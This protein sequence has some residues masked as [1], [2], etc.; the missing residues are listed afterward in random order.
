[1]DAKLQSV[2]AVPIF[3]PIRRWPLLLLLA[4]FSATQ[5]DA[6]LDPAR[7]NVLLL[8]PDEMSLS[9]LGAVVQGYE[10]ELSRA[11]SGHVV[12]S[13]D[14]VNSRVCSE[15]AETERALAW[16]KTKYGTR[17]FD[18]M[19][20]V[21][22]P[23]TQFAA[24]L[25]TSQFSGAPI[26][27]VAAEDVMHGLKLRNATGVTFAKEGRATLRAA[28]QMLP[29]TR[30]VAILGGNHPYDAYINDPSIRMLRKEAPG[31]DFIDLTRFPVSEQKQ[32]LANL[33]PN[34]VAL[35]LF[36]LHDSQ[37]AVV[38]PEIVS[39]LAPTPTPLFAIG[40]G[41]LGRGITGGF[42][43][44]TSQ[45]GA[46][47]AV[48]SERVLRGEPAESIPVTPN[49]AGKFRFDSRELKRWN[50]P[51]GR[52]PAGSEVL[53]EEPGI[54]SQHRLA[55]LGTLAALALQAILIGALLLERQRRRRAQLSLAEA[56]WFEKLVGE[57][58]NSLA[59]LQPGLV[60]D[61][62]RTVL[63]RVGDHLQADGAQLYAGRVGQPAF[64]LRNVWTR[65]EAPAAAILEGPG[66]PL[67]QSFV[68]GG[69]ELCIESPDELPEDLQADRAEFAR[70]GIQSLL[71]IPVAAGGQTAAA[72]V[73][74]RTRSPYRCPEPLVA[75][76]RTV[77]ELLANTLAVQDSNLAASRNEALHRSVLQALP[78]LITVLDRDGCV[79]GTSHGA[80]DKS[81]MPDNLRSLKVGTSYRQAWSGSSQPNGNAFDPSLSGG[82]D[83]GRLLQS[84]DEVLSGRR[85]SAHE[86]VYFQTDKGD[87]WLDIWIQPLERAEGGALIRHRDVSGA[88]RAELMSS[89]NLEEISHMNRIAALG[90]LASSLAHELNQPLTAILANAEAAHT[91]VQ[92]QTL[93]VAELSAALIDIR[94]DGQRA[95]KVIRNMRSLLKKG[96][97]QSDP[98][99]INGLITETV[100]LV[101]ND[102]LLRHVKL[103]LDLAPGPITVMANVIQLQ[104]VILNLISN[105][106]D[107]MEKVAPDQ[108]RLVV[109]TAPNRGDAKV[110]VEV[111]DSG[112]GIPKAQRNRVFDPFFTTRR[113]GLGVGLSISRSI[114]EAHGGTIWVEDGV[115]TGA[116]FRFVL[117]MEL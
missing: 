59:N 36:Y 41:G 75:Q 32:R 71:A 19:V 35:L 95:D 63:E 97:V 107:A 14:Y 17:R 117:P 86:E 29:A 65:G 74:Y 69:K 46:N 94:Q 39:A 40:V 51:A 84:V 12:F 73:L 85:S 70:C 105:A 11:L 58:S 3:V 13:I 91:L 102:A 115:G 113:E 52:L 16:M 108:R 27:F 5:G 99:D 2:D 49:R 103:Q 22:L 4:V 18:L 10:A 54:W 66:L 34:S 8:L 45:V 93:D 6:G 55:I 62:I 72:L 24:L 21:S 79:M 30:H 110:V 83:R 15:A 43:V 78:A 1:L 48:L 61:G 33:P 96:T 81:W 37:G 77:A 89:R 106:M 98:A 88:R 112:K 104:Q 26:V 68:R 28:V 50:I 53:F 90:E 116:K 100:R 80:A 109:R 92:R 114:V 44:D 82:D 9:Q 64:R 111:E 42:L 20:P 31:L 60:S 38:G 76:L 47:A 25:Q 67:I 7:K 87:R 23:L 101:R 57:M 56:I